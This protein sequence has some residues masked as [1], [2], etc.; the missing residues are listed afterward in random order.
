MGQPVVEAVCTRSD[1]PHQ[2]L[3]IPQSQQPQEEHDDAPHP[4]E[5]EG[6]PRRVVGRLRK[7][8]RP[9]A[10]LP[11]ERVEDRQLRRLRRGLARDAPRL[12]LLPPQLLSQLPHLH[13]PRAHLFR[14]PHSRCR[15]HNRVRWWMGVGAVHDCAT[16]RSMGGGKRGGKRGGR[17][18]GRGGGRGGRG[19]RGGGGGGGG[20]RGEQQAARGAGPTVGEECLL[21]CNPLETVCIGRCNHAQVC[22]KC[23]VRLRFKGAT[24]ACCICKEDLPTVVALSVGD[25]APF[26]DLPVADMPSLSYCPDVHC[27]DGA[28][29]SHLSALEAPICPLCQA[30]FPSVQRLRDHLKTVHLQALCEV[31]VESRP[32]FLAEQ[33]LYGTAALRK[34][35]TP[36]N[37]GP[38]DHR[39]CHLCKKRLV[40][41]DAHATHMNVEHTACFL[42]QR[43]GESDY[44]RDYRGLE[45]HFRKAHYPCMEPEC[46][47]AK[48]KVFEDELGLQAHAV[49]VHNR[50]GK[51][52]RL[53][54]DFTYAPHP[55]QEPVGN[56][57]RRGR[58]RARGRGDSQPADDAAWDAPQPRAAPAVDRSAEANAAALRARN[59]ATVRQI[60]GHLGEAKFAQLR[61]LSAQVRAAEVT[62]KQYVDRFLDLFGSD[63]GRFF[64]PLVAL[65]PDPVL[66]SNLTNVFTSRRRPSPAA[67]PAVHADPRLAAAARRQ[68]E[69]DRL[70]A[71]MRA[72]SVARSRP[73]PPRPSPASSVPLGVWGTQS[74]MEDAP[75]EAFPALGPAGEEVQTLSTRRRAPGRY[76]DDDD[77]GAPRGKGR[78]KQSQRS[79]QKQVLFRYG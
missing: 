73:S 20:E 78:K 8:R 32:L 5:E 27:F 19:G 51:G 1:E 45:A 70:A 62:P 67:A 42:C 72:A 79:R 61:T 55:A 68:E 37:P 39:Q 48:F 59:D 75:Q 17:R 11:V 28:V 21:C 36:T 74:S 46:L 6:Q 49:A 3:Q 4:Q 34:H 2:P 22:A 25:V 38:D 47:E 15:I 76:D 33:A 14:V 18:G 64:P 60:R 66:R 53:D 71:E 40:D 9:E 12:K 58:G 31:C 52:R 50:G 30:G 54:I 35:L 56:G 16:A 13:Q 63:A 41:E 24:R 44:Y 43:H 29:L 69:E 10:P 57:G 65:L 23:T 77:W 7:G 26:E